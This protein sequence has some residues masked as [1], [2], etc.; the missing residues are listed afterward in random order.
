MKEGQLEETSYYYPAADIREFVRGLP[1][2]DAHEHIIPKLP[3]KR[4]MIMT[5]DDSFDWEMFDKERAAGFE[6]TWFLL[7]DE[8]TEYTPKDADIQLHFDKSWGPL[9]M[10]KERFTDLGFNPTSCR[11]HRLFWRSDNYDFPL[12]AMN[13]F[14]ID[15]SRIGGRP[16]F[17]VIFSRMIPILEIPIIVADRP[18]NYITLWTPA[19][20]MES[21]FKCGYGPVMVLAH[22]TDVCIDRN[23][24]S[25]FEETVRMADKYG[26]KIVSLR[27]YMGLIK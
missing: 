20:N 6:S 17:P 9:Y 3:K 22:P 8:V 1:V 4:Y 19:D 7:P 10:Q 25:C 27:Q 18:N 5:H 14:N 15:T 26:Y 12:L 16:Y 13:G 24:V 11:I 2:I 23:M 21:V